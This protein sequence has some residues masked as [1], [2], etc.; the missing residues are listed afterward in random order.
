MESRKIPNSAIT[1]S[2]VWGVGHEAWR[3]RLRNQ[4]ALPYDEYTN[5]GSWKAGAYSSEYLQIDLGTIV[6]VTMVAT[7]GRP[8]YYNMWVKKYSLAYALN[9]STFVEYKVHG[10][11]K[12]GWRK[13]CQFP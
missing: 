8:M 9:N 11:V 2:S 10:I 7:Q 5:I 13:S 12:V 6:D 1:A 3:G 4:P